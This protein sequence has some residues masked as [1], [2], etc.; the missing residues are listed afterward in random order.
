MFQVSTTSGATNAGAAVEKSKLW[1]TRY[2]QLRELSGWVDATAA[3]LWFPQPSPQG[4]LLPG[5]DRGHRLEDW[6]DA[7]PLAA[8]IYPALLGI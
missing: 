6:P 5:V 3:L 1:L 2:G 7:R 8:E 4:P